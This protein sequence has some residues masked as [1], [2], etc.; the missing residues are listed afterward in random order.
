M[1]QIIATNLIEKYL[2][3]KPDSC[4]LSLNWVTFL[5]NN[6]ILIADDGHESTITQR[7]QARII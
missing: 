2:L 5:W 6:Y 4:I 1:G 7:N 3:S